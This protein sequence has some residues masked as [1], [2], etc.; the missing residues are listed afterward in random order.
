MATSESTLAHQ[1]QKKTDRQHILDAPDTYI[2]SIENVDYES[3][4]Y[5]DGKIIN[6]TISL[7]PGLYK[8]FDEGVVN[9]RDHAVRCSQAII[10]GKENILPVTNIDIGIDAEGVITLINDGNG[11]DVAMHPE[12]N[13]WIPELIFGHLR[14]S[15][16]YDKTE[17]K[18]VGGKNG[19]GF[20]LVLIWSSWGRVETIDHVRGLKY[21]Q[22]FSDNL[23]VIGT[24]RIVKHKGKP[25]TKVVFKP[26]YQRL[27]LANLSDDIIKLFRRRVCDIAAVTDRTVKVKYNSEL[28]PV[29]NFTK[30]IDL[31]IGPKETTERVYEEASERWEYAVCISPSGE[32]AQV[33]FVNG[34]FTSKGGKHVEYI[35]NQIVRKLQA[36]ITKKKK[37]DVK[38]A[39]IKE[40]LM[41][42]LRC[43]IENPA[44]DS[45]TKDFMTTAMS[46]FGSTCSVTDKFIEKI[47]KMGVMEAA[48]ALTEVKETKAAKKT[49]GSKT[50]NVRGIPKL[51]DANLAGTAKSRECTIIFCEGDSAKAGIV[52]GLSKSDRDIIGVYPMRGK[53][54]NVRG[55]ISRKISENK[56]IKEIKQILGLES[57][58]TYTDRDV[59]KSLRYGRIIFMTDQ[60]LDGS[61]IKGLGLNL[62]D[63][64]WTSLSKI[65][66]FIG[67][68]NTPILKAHKGAQELVFYN[69]GE[70]EQWK[71]ANDSRGWKIK[72]YKGL[73][74]STAKEFKEYFAHKKIV[75]FT[76]TG[77][78]SSDAIDMVFN[79]KRADD[80]K[81]W[82]SGY[83]RELY[84]DTNSETVTFND[85]INRE[86]I[87]F[88]KYDCDRSIPNLMDGLKISLRKILFA[89]FKKRLNTEIKVA[90]FSGYVSEQ[91]AY[92]HGEQSLNGAIVGM[93]QNFVGSNNINLFMPCGQFGTRLQGGK[94]SAS[95]RYIYTHLNKLTRLIFPEADDKVLKYLNDDGFPVEPIHYVP[96]IP[97]ILVNGS[98][99][100]G[101]GFSTDIMCYNVTDIIQY[102][103]NKLT[104]SSEPV[105]IRPYY[106]G[107][108]GTITAITE[109]KY[110]IKGCYTIEGPNTV[111]VTELP[112]GLWTEDFKEH[113][114]ELMEGKP[115]KT[116]EKEVAAAAA[117]GEKKSRKK[118]VTGLVKEYRDLSTDVIIDFTITFNAGVIQEL[119]ATTDDNGCNPLE[120]LLKLYTTQTTTNMHAFD[121]DEKLKKYDTVEEIIE[122]Y[123]DVR[124][125]FY[126]DRKDYQIDALTDELMVISNKVRYIQEIL[127]DTLDLRKKK[128]AEIIELLEEKDYDKIDDDSDYKYLVKMPMDSVSEENVERLIQERDEKTSQLELL[129]EKPIS[130]IW[131]EEL[132]ELAVEYN[133]S[134]AANSSVAV[135]AKKPKSKSQPKKSGKKKVVV[136]DE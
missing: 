123:Y 104:G 116:S 111:R 125:N 25:Y 91:A 11:I 78:E 35:M 72:Y 1:Y 6:K 105:T 56:E 119:T 127:N 48:C 23:S 124:Y 21:T 29:T 5:E 85:F 102:L 77:E 64:E 109:Q 134:I 37:V 100:I 41:L 7:N 36:H 22:E 53:L 31:Y 108:A 47:A 71:S 69:D 44:F 126:E 14:T 75:T 128:K 87:H 9:C 96:I 133:S 34:I 74:T 54:L 79:K 82:L 83:D 121:A 30:Y 117:A 113:L 98:K 26:D 136:V 12:Y 46:N 42:F 118:K 24:P 84:L 28:I 86:M 101:T 73:G 45:Q 20:K 106:E 58:K 122:D 88:S 65:S 81:S 97:M 16:N 131:L 135:V 80:R 110:L 40:Q 27:G 90:Q 132:E 63:S 76:H 62:F 60:D 55:E 89:A 94:D 51:I 50:K 59:E 43:D 8:L 17:K 129:K 107:F 15:T 57:G 66:G 130:Q 18:I 92:H 33:S 93:A 115:E 61:H 10:S 2:G 99:G 112:I 32:F 19:F 3:Y 120:K 114:E 52:S 39:V 13:V 4:I 38:P 68:M 103:K 70:Y 95:E 49:D 67:F